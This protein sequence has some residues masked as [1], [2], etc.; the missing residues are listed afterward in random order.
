M[1]LLAKIQNPTD[2]IMAVKDG[3]RRARFEIRRRA[4]GSRETDALSSLLPLPL[5][6]AADAVFSVVETAA[7][8]FRAPKD[9]KSDN[10]T[11]PRSLG[12]YFRAFGATAADEDAFANEL[13]YATKSLLRHFGAEEFLVSERAFESVRDR[14]NAGHGSQ[15]AHSSGETDIVAF[16]AAL[17]V[18]IAAVRPVQRVAL[19][20]NAGPRNLMLA[21][22][23]YCAFVIALA[24][25]LATRNPKEEANKILS[26]ADLTV[27]A[28]FGE[29]MHALR[30]R[31]PSA[32]LASEFHALLRHL[33]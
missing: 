19:G 5:A 2:S 15:S 6:L 30:D 25:V 26:L 31:K 27:D 13:Y 21:P 16:C 17:A 18:E 22:N 32:A 33:P 1:L 14:M 10:L 3:L 7:L 23:A 9:R 29:L 24:I 8:G 28:C 20:A 11:F 4:R 12:A